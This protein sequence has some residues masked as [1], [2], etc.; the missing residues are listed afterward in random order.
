MNADSHLPALEEA[1]APEFDTAD[2]VT[3]F[4]EVEPAAA[5]AVAPAT[6]PAVAPLPATASALAWATACALRASRSVGFRL[7]PK[8]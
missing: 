8:V 3:A 7:P 4:E 6:A 2:P 5:W 1:T